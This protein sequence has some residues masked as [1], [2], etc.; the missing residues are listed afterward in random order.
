MVQ[1][2]MLPRSAQRVLAVVLAIFMLLSSLSPVASVAA[3]ETG[4]QADQ[5]LVNRGSTWKYLDDGSDQ[6]TKWR[7][8]EFDDR[9]WKEGA[10]P[11]GYPAGE[12]HGEFPEIATVIGYGDDSKNKYATTYF[13]TTFNV[14]DVSKISS[15][16]LITAGIDDSAI[17]YLNGEE[18]A[19]VNLPKDHEIPY[20][21]Y[22]EEFGLN[23]SNESTNKTVQL[24][25]EQMSLIKEGENVLAVE[26][27][28]DRPSSSDVFL[29]LELKSIYAE[30]TDPS[31]YQASHIS[32]APGADE[33]QYN[34]S[35]YSQETKEPGVI[36]YAKVTD[37]NTKEFPEESAITVEAALAK[38]SPGY[39]AN[40]ATITAIVGSSTYVYRL[41][42]GNGQWTETYSFNTKETDNY[43]FLFMGDPQLG[44]GKVE[45]DTAGWVNTVNKAIEKF[46]DTS[47]IYSAGDQV[48]NANSEE[49]YTGFFAPELLKK[50]PTATTIGNHDNSPFYEYHFNTPNQNPALGNS[51]NA[52]GDYYFTY[53]D[54]LIMNL[55][56]NNKN[57]AEHAQFLEE[58][59]AAN[60][61]AKWKVLVFHHSIYSAAN[62]SQES[63]IIQLRE[64]LVPTIDA[65]GIDVVLSGHD[66]GYVRTY[67]MKDL[68]TIKNQ[69]VDKNGAVVNPT[70]TLYITANSSSG[71]KYY[72]LK[73]DP[74]PYAAKRE[75]LKVPTFMNVDVTPK[76]LTFTTY[77]VDT[78]AVT[79]T[80]TIVKDPSV[81][82]ELPELK[83][84]KIEASG[85]VIPT[86]PLTFYPEVSF[87]V[88]GKNVTGG[89]YDIAYED[90]TYKTDKEGQIAISPDGKVTVLESA[91]SGQVQVWAEV[92]KDGK[93]FTTDKLTVTIV[94]HTEQKLL[95]KG[96]KWKYLDNG[97]DQ[98]KA[99]KEPGFDDNS[100]KSAPAP[101]G[102]PA[103]EKRPLFGNIASVIS[104]GPDSQNKFPTTYFRTEFEI[105][106]V[107]KIGKQGQI[108]F[109]ID[110]SVILYLNGHEIDRHNLP[111]G[112]ITYDQYLSDLKGSNVADESAYE[113]FYLDEADL[114]YL[115]EGKNV[116]AAEV[117]QDRPTSSDV[118][119]DMELIVNHT[120]VEDNEPEVD[121][122]SLNVNENQFLNGQYLIQGTGN[123]KSQLSLSIDGE[124]VSNTSTIFTLPAKIYLEGSGI[125]SE[126]GFIN[127][128]FV[129]GQLVKVFEKNIEGYEG[130]EIPVDPKILKPGVNKVTVRAGNK[131]S[132]TDLEGNHDDFTIRNVKLVLSDGTELM[133]PSISKDQKVNLGDG[134][135]PSP[136]KSGLSHD[137]MM[138]IP[139][140]LSASLFYQWD[141]TAAEDGVH[142]LE[143]MDET[144]GLPSRK[145]NVKVD[146]TAPVIKVNS[147][148]EGKSYKGTITVNADATDEGSGVLKIDAYLDGEPVEMG[149]EIRVGDLDA[150]DHTVKVVAVDQV[151]NR[152][153]KEVKFTTIDENPVKPQNPYPADYSKGVSTNAKLRVSVQDP[154]NDQLDVSFYQAYRY[155]FADG[156]DHKAYQG[157]ADREP[158]LVKTP[159][160]ENEFQK[161]QYDFIAAS[162]DKH[163]VNDAVEGFPYQRFDFVIKEDTSNAK[164]VE[165]VWEGHSLPDRRVTMYAWNYNTGAWQEVS[166][167][168]SETEKDFELRGELIVKDMV[169]DQ[170]ASIMIQDLVP[171][172]EEFDFSFAWITDTQN[173]SRA[174]PQI[175]DS[176]TQWIVDNKKE[177]N[178]QYVMHTGDIVDG[179]G[180]QNQWIN[181]DRSMKILDDAKMPYGVLAGNHDVGE[182]PNYTTYGKWFGRDRFADQPHYGGDREN[183]RDHFDLISYGGHDFIIVY[184]GWQP[185]QE[186]FDWANKVLKRYSDRNAILA[187]H[188]YIASSG[189][190]EG[191]GQDIFEKVVAPNEN[192]F[193]VLNGHA[194]GNPK[195]N[196]KDVE[197]RTVY[198]VFTNYQNQPEGGM[199][200]F[201]MLNF[202]TE[203]QKLYMTTYSPYKDDYN[204][205]ADQYEEFALDLQLKPTQKRVATD[206][207]GIEVKTDHLIGEVKQ[208]ESNSEVSVPWNGLEGNKNYYWYVGVSDRFGGTT[209]SDLWG[210]T[211]RKGPEPM[212]PE[213]SVTYSNIKTGK[214]I[215]HDKSVS[216]TV[217]RSAE[218]KN[219]I[220]FTGEYA[221]F[222]GDGF[223]DKTVTLKPKKDGAIIDFKGTEIEKVIIE[224]GGVAEIRGAENVKKFIYEKGASK[225]SIKF[226]D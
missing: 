115:V 220:V 20:S 76:S 106:D 91:V 142:T 162:D 208:V 195:L 146:N 18:I 24:G 4:E 170:K 83:S 40:E 126:D 148:E 217:D 181:A 29:D 164:T 96:S 95:E 121:S 81:E 120:L 35:W 184:L 163:L 141:T 158:P 219:G 117:H 201:R 103:S 10:A 54:T 116:L 75:Q 218:I 101:L 118:Y 206:Y 9:A 59:V 60:P 223:T 36:Q 42:N 132:P 37:G 105:E 153:E 143:L 133:D 78:M 194:L 182:N 44:S 168:I 192:I 2:P 107:S 222:H 186:S 22:V 43:N 159:E 48:N 47:F 26:V 151:G 200:Y 85:T 61:N 64:D 129:N 178:I 150:G 104:F 112:D 174:Y 94:D 176:M 34:F 209:E 50:Y 161:D 52:G 216:I 111:E 109:G 8:A 119:W 224:K 70:G 138:T 82:V 87:S 155:D 32:F 110:D 3:A 74:E 15:T 45:S 98:G 203:N 166:S 7:G 221:E 185:T 147:L 97:S 167:A 180:D 165:A 226:V 191:P 114:S 1:I 136:D 156:L 53:G 177:Q 193:L 12:V 175:Y 68:Q 46:P 169:R 145:V 172:P 73:P 69:M 79:D 211:T 210:F 99:W 49:E 100:W 152:G 90:I 124:K 139:E 215:V 28:Q 55:N 108:N 212:I 188:Q 63:S 65:L 144:G 30:P 179:H 23:D 86:E 127:S 93:T 56:S 31:G 84:V 21:A 102:Y 137:F 17:I 6:G 125:Q 140:T 92:V 198:E 67:Q 88:T 135:P 66:H 80:Y 205:Y 41:G 183:N 62:H 123:S 157:V 213:K 214:V 149:S 19:R 154:S 77:R 160:G 11:L 72:N 196:T 39:S 130:V 71:S 131:V 204:W 199:G 197:G 57:A 113:T 89:P 13:R 38:A 14:D 202:D 51:N 16:G 5:V 187:V 58:T 122:L 173:Y 225:E 27:H 189:K 33:T 128:V 207:I 134:F 190:Y 25:Q 171:T